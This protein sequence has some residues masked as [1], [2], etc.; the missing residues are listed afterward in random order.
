M[1]TTYIQS[2]RSN[3]T[4]TPADVR[5]EIISVESIGVVGYVKVTFLMFRTAVGGGSLADKEYSTDGG[6]GW[7]PMTTTASGDPD[8]P[9]EFKTLKVTGK[10]DQF[11][12][13]WKAGAD[14][15]IL[16]AFT[17]LLVRITPN[18]DN[19]PL[20]GDDGDTVESE[21]FNIDFRPSAPPILYP[22]D[23]FG[24]EDQPEIVF[25][26]PASVV[27]ENFHFSVAVDKVATFDGPSLQKI[28]TDTDPTKFEHETSPG[29][30]LA[31]PPGG[32]ASSN[33]GHRIRLKQG[34][35][36]LLTD[37][38]WYVQVTLGIV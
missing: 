16:T 20:L 37:G 8:Y 18:D 34:E 25:T 12:I 4:V 17:D 30:W 22:L 33:A 28:F 26:V 15:G 9:S 10:G 38:L 23:V 7:N 27:A 3:F 21:E 13:Y 31:F 2:N 6:S 32:V 29:T 35:L 1:P 19:D 11:S 5:V 24:E 14:L 36:T